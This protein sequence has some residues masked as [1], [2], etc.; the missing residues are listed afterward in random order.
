[1]LHRDPDGGS[2]F[3]TLS[4]DDKVFE[5]SPRIRKSSNKMTLYWG[6]NV[7]PARYLEAV[8]IIND[9]KEKF[10]PLKIVMI[11]ATLEAEDIKL[12]DVRSDFENVFKQLQQRDMKAELQEVSELP[13]SMP[14][15]WA[16]SILA[17]KACL[18]HYEELCNICKRMK[19]GDRQGFVPY[20][21]IGH[22]ERAI[23]ACMQLSQ[24]DPDL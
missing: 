2:R 3:A 23:K 6:E 15:N 20:V 5:I 18:G 14:G 4:Q 12:S 11:D 8:S 16:I 22:I 7:I 21:E 10:F 9:E 13:L 1:M 24:A 17:A 19:Q